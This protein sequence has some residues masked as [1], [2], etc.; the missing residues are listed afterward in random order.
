MEL[1]LGRTPSPVDIRPMP[2]LVET[3][4]AELE[5]PRELPAQVV[6][7]L[8]GTYGIDRDAVGAFLVNELPKLEDYEIDLALSPVFTP[9]LHDQAVFADLLGQESVPAAQ[10]PELIRQLVTRPTCAQLATTDGQVHAVPLREVSL[11][12]FVHRLRL[13]ATIP[14]ALFKL[15]TQLS[16]TADLPVLKAIA[17]RAVWEKDARGEILVRYLTS[18]TD[19]SA[20]RLDDA[21]EL[22]KLVEI[23]QPTDVADLLARIPH[24]LQVL[25]QEINEGTG[26]KPFFNERVQDLHGGGRDQR[27]QDNTRITAKESE[28]A[29]LARLQKVLAS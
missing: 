29:F 7:H 8:S 17:R 9:T 20:Y 27:R 16:P 13:D 4:A 21:I 24:W 15:V 26:T 3:L 2:T 12:R 22:L 19:D 5:R 1:L 23:Y 11:E 10:W 14:E 18:A 25:R 6:H 28:R